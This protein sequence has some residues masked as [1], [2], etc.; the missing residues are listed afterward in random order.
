MKKVLLI[1]D[2]ADVR[3]NTADIL[4]LAGY[5]V[6]VAENG[7]VG[8]QTAKQFGPDI[9]ICD[10]MMP[11]L[12]GFSVLH[13]LNEDPET[14]RIPFIFLTAKSGKTDMRMGMN[15]GAD[16]YLTKPFDE[17]EL[18][19]AIS[20]RLKKYDF[21]R[22]DIA[23]DLEGI[24]T[25]FE[26]ASQYM[27]MESLSRDHGLKQYKKKA[28]VFNEGDA[29]QDL[30]FIDSGTIKTYKSTEDGKEFVT[31]LYSA[32]DFI[33]QLSLLGKSGTYAETAT[34]LEDAAVCTI[35]KEDFTKL[36]Y[37]NHVVSEKF[38]SMVSNNLMAVQ[39]QLVSMAFASVRQRAAKMLL[40]LYDKGIVCD[41]TNAG[42]GIPREDFAGMIGTATETAIRTLSDF[43][44]EGLIATDHG[45][46]I[47]IL[48]K[49]E[50][51]HVADFK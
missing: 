3:E 34:V 7:K 32:G 12:N 28:I 43:K 50:L 16:D 37:G 35:P 2:N 1:E 21:L 31:G 24:N 44:D 18:L 20:T 47:V 5:N 40:E 8:I 38:I 6:A 23:K 46:R 29:A 30:Y 33:G 27:D 25:F 49:E 17:E 22:K 51:Q 19:D 4:R 36:L 14:A 39:E 13:L 41:K 15:L 11:G 45:R 9:I 10:I 42:I 26:E 48:D